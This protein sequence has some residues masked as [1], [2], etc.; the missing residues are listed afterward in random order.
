MC[1]VNF[2]CFIRDKLLLVFKI[3]IIIGRLIVVNGGPNVE[4]NTAQKNNYELFLNYLQPLAE[5]CLHPL[6]SIANN[7]N[8][9]FSSVNE[10]SVRS[11]TSGTLSAS[12]RA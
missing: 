1:L 5:K 11:F 3:S 10:G 9:I 2:V 6:D 12:A 8:S 4:S 7:V